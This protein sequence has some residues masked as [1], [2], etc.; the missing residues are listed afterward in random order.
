MLKLL[1]KKFNY[2]IIHLILLYKI[3][4]ENEAIDSIFNTAITL[5]T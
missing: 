5:I 4:L 3:I 1:T 2:K